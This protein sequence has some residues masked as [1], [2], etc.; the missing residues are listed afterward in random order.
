MSAAVFGYAS[1]VSTASAGE[2]LGRPV[3]VAAVARLRGWARGWTLA[4]DNATSEKTFAR[5][6]GSQPRFCLG[7]NVEPSD[8]PTDPNGVLIALSEPELERLDLREIRYHR[9]DVTDAVA[10]EAADGAPAPGFDAIYTYTARPEH[11][12]PTPPRG[13]DRDRHLPGDDRGRLRRARPGSAR[14][15]SE[16]PRPHH[17]SRSPRRPWSATGSRP[18][19]RADG[20]RHSGRASEPTVCGRR[21]SSLVA[22]A[23]NS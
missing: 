10:V 12:H 20:S 2:T 1:L 13:R 11:H 4:R 18:A 8:R 22:S 9:V 14:A 23:M 19:T 15:L 16:R 3:E 6:D 5:P 17:R 7:L 21:R